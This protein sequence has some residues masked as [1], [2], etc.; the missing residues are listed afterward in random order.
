MR[1]SIPSSVR[2]ALCQLSPSHGRARRCRR[3]RP[4]S[5]AEGEIDARRL[6]QHEEVGSALNED[7]R[8][9]VMDEPRRPTENQE[10]ARAQLHLIRRIRWSP[11]RKRK[12]HTVRECDAHALAWWGR[13]DRSSTQSRPQHL[14]IEQYGRTSRQSRRTVDKSCGRCCSPQRRRAL[15]WCVT[16]AWLVF[17]CRVVFRCHRRRQSGSLGLGRLRT[18]RERHDGLPRCDRLGALILVL[19]AR[20]RHTDH[21]S[22]TKTPGRAASE[23]SGSSAHPLACARCAR[24]C[25]R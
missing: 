24:L 14:P 16:A 7:A 13:R 11:H 5:F 19:C 25:K 15:L 9:A 12:P 17:A 6:R 21:C 22:A 3:S 20:A 23:R 18:K 2:A 8:H 1:C 10:V 4:S